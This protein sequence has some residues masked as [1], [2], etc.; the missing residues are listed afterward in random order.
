MHIDPN[1]KFARGLATAA[2]VSIAGSG[3]A[4]NALFGWNSGHTDL[5]RSLFAVAAV[6]IDIAKML[7]LPLAVIAWIKGAWIKS[8]VIGSLWVFALSFSLAAAMGF[9]G[10]T[11]AKVVAE[12]Q[13]AARAYEEHKRR[14]KKL[15]DDI[16][17]AKTAKARKTDEHPIHKSTGSCM[18]ATAP[19]SITFC[20]EYLAKVGE[21]AA[22]RRDAPPVPK[23]GE[24]DPQVAFIQK[25]LPLTRAEQIEVG[26]AV[27]FAV[28]FE[29][30]GAFGGY[31]LS[32]TVAK[33]GLGDPAARE[34]R[35]R[36]RRRGRPEAGAGAKTEALVAIQG[37][38]AS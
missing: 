35:Q 10:T 29:V 11:R 38:R 31:A 14:V 3:M 7:L 15:E 13:E 24:A 37:G 26:L 30:F 12:R 25:L 34:R 16:E 19:T 28:T 36:R 18:A 8:I 27:A 9:A 33:P 21:L 22:L 5:E 4:M 17:V 23:L 20:H 2:L 1:S 6:S 32:R